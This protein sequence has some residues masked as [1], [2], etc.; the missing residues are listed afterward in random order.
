MSF[1]E[2]KNRI[3]ALSAELKMHSYRYYVLAM[4]SISDFEFD[5]LLEELVALETQF[6]ELVDPDSPTQ[7]VGGYITKEFQTVKHRWPMLSLG[8]TYNEQELLD[9]DQRIKKAIGDN[10]EY[11][12]E[13]KF[14]GLSMSLTYENGHLAR[15]VT[16]GD[17]TQGDV[18]TENVK[19]IRSIPKRLH[20]GDYPA[21]FEIRGEVFMHRKAFDRLNEERLENGEAAYANPRNF[22]SGTIKLQDSAEVAKRPLDSFMYFLYTERRLFDTHWES[23]QAVKN[24][25]FPVNDESRLCSNISEVLQFIAEWE[26]KRFHLSYDI[27]G[28]V[29]KVNSYSQQEELGFTAKSPRWA[30]AYKYKAQQVETELQS[31]SYQVGRTG[32]V[33]PVA[34]LKPILLAGT[35]VKRATLHNANEIVRLDLHE[36]DWVFVEKGG[37]IIP[38]IIGVNLQK[39]LAGAKP[40]HYITNCPVCGTTL[41]RKEGEAAFY[42]PNDEGCAPQIVG[43]MQHFTGRKV[44]NI[45]G[46]GDETI[47]TLFERGFIRHI[48]DIYTLYSKAEELKQLDRFGEKSINNMLDGIEKSKQQPFEK[49][50]F[51]LGIRYVGATVAKK[52]ASYFKSIDNIIAASFDELNAVEEIGDRIAKSVIEYFDNAQHREEIEKLKALGLQ[53]TAEEK[54]V[55]LA[56]EK[57]SGKT[58][59]IS[60]TFSRSRDELKD[61]IEQNGGKILSSISAKL[62]YLVAGDNMGPAKLEKATKLNIPIISDEELL[63]MI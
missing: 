61:I 54:E 18:V 1:E 57:L 26:S 20:A 9:F 14:D 2:A 10:F 56:S 46:L 8:N 45:D 25:G 6:P 58:F 21:D 52:L 49:V 31:V 53:F 43:K 63:A 40:I 24:W 19:T 55:V 4:P 5:K 42:C 32:A 3:A 22:A 39:R 34:N 23:L 15:A 48:S 16:R 51:G 27:D 50:L 41:E 11:V 37:E 12:V 47:E 36:G 7:N 59:V 17:G 33:T 29:I 62:D 60:G 13:L 28:I 38:K 44:M 30:I 35:T